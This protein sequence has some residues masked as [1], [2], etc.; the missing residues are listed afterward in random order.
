MRLHVIWSATTTGST[1]LPSRA[2]YGPWAFATGRLP[3]SPWQNEYAERLIGTIRRECVDHLI[4]FEDVS[5]QSRGCDRRDR[6]VRGSDCD[7]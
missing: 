5:A 1:V 7:L 4:V 6:H 2:G 3:G